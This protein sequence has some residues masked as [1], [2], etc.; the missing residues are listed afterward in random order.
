MGKHR[1]GG[2]T[3]SKRGAHRG[4]WIGGF[5]VVLA[6]LAVAPVL[7]TPSSPPTSSS[8]YLVAP[9]S[10][11]GAAGLWK[12][13]SQ[14]VAITAIPA[15]STVDATE[16]VYFSSDNGITSTSKTATATGT[17][18]LSFPVVSEGSHAIKFW[19]SD[20]SGTESAH[21]PGFINIDET[22]PTFT[23]VTGLAPVA[24]QSDAA[25]WSNSTTG[26]VT[27]VATDTVPSAGVATSGVRSISR[28]INSGS[29]DTTTTA[30]WHFTYAKG[31]GGVVEGSNQVI[32]SALDWAAN[33][34]IGTGYINIDTV[35][36]S[37]EATPTLASSAT[38]GWRTTPLLVTLN[39][40]DASSGVP[41]GGTRYGVNSSWNTYTAPFTVGT[42][43][44][45]GSFNVQYFSTDRAGNV[46]ATHTAYVNI[47]TSIPTVSVTTAPS[48]SSGWYNKNVAVTIKGVDTVSGIAM[49]QYR[50]QTTPLPDW[51]TAVSNQFTV[52][53]SANAKLKYGYQALDIAGNVSLPATLALN[54]DSIAPTTYGKN[55]TGAAGKSIKV[56]YKIKDNL[57]PKAQTVWV[58]IKNSSGKTMKTV[59]FT[60]TKNINTWYSFKWSTQ[61]AGKY[62]YYVYGKDLAGNPQKTPGSARITVK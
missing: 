47:D 39:A 42:A 8:S 28:I 60:N 35:A 31:T 1:Q 16:T 57:S 15:A 38:T 3:R 30:T 37:T 5:A 12:N 25:L 19:A 24:T 59:T 18:T 62:T 26:T 36:P 54:M 58:K 17:A 10:A 45:N 33:L 14:T 40:T 43:T 49:T 27:L 56:E 41:A 52:L 29:T 21:S 13:A 32:Y 2:R 48:R 34:G 22:N 55:V 61:K 11:Q 6:L 23:V 7:A 44:S 50:L 46:E 9:T 20:T 51:T 53:A 4:L